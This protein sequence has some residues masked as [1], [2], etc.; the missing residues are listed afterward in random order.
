MREHEVR[1]HLLRKA[2]TDIRAALA[3]HDIV[4]P[5]VDVL[6]TR[7]LE[8]LGVS[9]EEYERAVAWT[10]SKD[11]ERH[12]LEASRPSLPSSREDEL[13]ALKLVIE[14]IAEQYA[15]SGLKV[16]FDLK[17]AIAPACPAKR[18]KKRTALTALYLSLALGVLVVVISG[19]TVTWHRAQE[20]ACPQIPVPPDTVRGKATASEVNRAGVS[21]T[22]PS[23][24]VQPAANRAG[25]SCGERIGVRPDSS[26]K[27]Q[28]GEGMNTHQ[29]ATH[30][31]RV[32]RR[33]QSTPVGHAVG[34]A[35]SPA[36]DEGEEGG[37]RDE[38]RAVNGI[39]ASKRPRAGPLVPLGRDGKFPAWDLL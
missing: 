8:H 34:S 35:V 25:V 16:P 12:L 36:R 19:T 21:T 20:T 28:K 30:R 27:K 14:F 18:H 26:E 10:P 3:E 9:R 33:S 22:G 38:R 24:H 6:E 1:A 23:P 17:R 37:L 32:R 4:A 39:K 5:S 7:L 15:A 31:P 11:Y 29:P 13:A 2:F